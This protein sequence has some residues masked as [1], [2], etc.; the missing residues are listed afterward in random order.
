[1]VGV[2]HH[3]LFLKHLEGFRHVERPERLQ[4][5]ME[6][7]KTGALAGSVS[8]IEAIPAEQAWL[9]RVHD[10]KYVESIAM[11]DAGDPVVLDWG[12][13][14]ATAATP[15]AALYAAGAAVQGARLVLEGTLPSVFCAVRPPGHH[16]EADRAMGF[17][18]FNNIAVA[19]ADL[20]EE[21]DVSR[22]AI[23][24][25]DVHHGNGT[26]RMFADDDRVLYISIHQFPHYPGTG[27]AAMRGRGKGE[28]YT[29]NIPMGAGAGDRE[30]RSA[31]STQ[32]IPALESFRPEFILVSAGF[33][34]HRDDPL[35]GTEV[36]SEMFGEMTR[37]IMTCA[38][39]HCRGRIVSLLEG[40]YNLGAL[41]DSV[42]YHLSE[43]A[44]R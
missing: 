40:G 43:L 30:Y 8:F 28:G 4:A 15:Q 17:C 13:T 23:V 9:T 34:A 20:L 1:M 14:I 11:L 5:I 29:I 21:G 19:A 38:N 25:W 31:F 16:A 3:E 27:S 39:R 10:V 12:D 41:A 2:I 42:E 36:S 37:M 18:I 44:G 32:I 33:D 22:V 35:S 7:L 6:R 24:D 26:E